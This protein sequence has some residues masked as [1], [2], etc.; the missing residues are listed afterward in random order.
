MLSTF[1]V[2][3]NKLMFYYYIVTTQVTLSNKKPRFGPK[4]ATKEWWIQRIKDREGPKYLTYWTHYTDSQIGQFKA[5]AEYD[6]FALGEAFSA[7]KTRETRAQLLRAFFRFAR[8][9]WE[10]LSSYANNRPRYLKTSTLSRSS[11]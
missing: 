6:Y 5:L 7:L 9:A 3:I 1:I 10:S 2:C 8:I 11:P 4:I